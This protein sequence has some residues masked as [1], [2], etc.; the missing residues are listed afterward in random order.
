MDLGFEFDPDEMV[1]LA[2]HDISL[3]TA[4]KEY[5]AAR[6]TIAG[7]RMCNTT[8]GYPGGC[9][10]SARLRVDISSTA[11]RLIACRGQRWTAC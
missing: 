1:N 10:W 8:G 5:V 9:E 7:C 2:A 4:V 11:C 6:A 3:R